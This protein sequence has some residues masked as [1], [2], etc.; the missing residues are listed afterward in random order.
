MGKFFGFETNTSSHFKFYIFGIKLKVLKPSYRKL[1]GNYLHYN[2]AAEIPPATGL[3]REIQLGNLAILKM[4]DKICKQ[5]KL[6]YW[7]DFGT[8]LGAVRHK[9]FIPWDDDI[10]IGMMRDDYEKLIKIMQEQGDSNLF[11]DFSSNGRNSCFVKIRYKGLETAFVDIFPYDLYHSKTTAEEKKIL[12]D[13]TTK[14]KLRLKHA[15]FKTKD[16]NKLREKFAKI[17]RE[18]IQA[19]KKCSAEM[20]PSVFWGIDFPHSWK[21]RVY[22][23]ENIFP[24]KEI[25][26]EGTT[27][28][29]P[30]NSDFV[31][32]NVYGNYMK[33]PERTYP[34]H[35]DTEFFTEENRKRLTTLISEGNK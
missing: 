1:Q 18:E 2:S 35:T 30:N 27:L 25:V 17:T 29:C 24:L 8:L 15:L 28:P 23:W 11:I 4:L 21:N 20:Q 12:H 9:G 7:L 26:F 10:D 5:H 22:D 16:K 31:L 13:K 33:I 34:G 14:I 3:L 19:N 6:E 32:T